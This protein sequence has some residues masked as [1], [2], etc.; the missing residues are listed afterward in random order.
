MDTLPAILRMPDAL[1]LYNNRKNYFGAIPVT[2][3]ILKS[4]YPH[5]HSICQ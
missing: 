5:K 4:D 3:K 2:V 1:P